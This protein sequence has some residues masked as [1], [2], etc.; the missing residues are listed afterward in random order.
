MLDFPSVKSGI[1]IDSILWN[2]STTNLYT[3][4]DAACTAC[5]HSSVMHNFKVVWS[6]PDVLVVYLMRR[7]RGSQEVVSTPVII[8]PRLN[9]RKIFGKNYNMGDRI[10]IKQYRSDV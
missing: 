9:V 8:K 5:K 6:L 10:S 1:D 2:W 3:E 4:P 7:S